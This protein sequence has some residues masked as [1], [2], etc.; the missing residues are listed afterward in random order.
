[1]HGHVDLARLLLD[2][3]ADLYARTKYGA[4]VLTLA[5]ASGHL[6]TVRLLLE[7]GLFGLFEYQKALVSTFMS[8][9]DYKITVRNFTPN[10]NKFRKLFCTQ[11]P[12]LNISDIQIQIK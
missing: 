11:N 4:S 5:A 12:A 1:M 7:A 2:K 10:S 9:Y 3:G 6:S 8:I